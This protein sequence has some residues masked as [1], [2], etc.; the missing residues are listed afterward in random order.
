M[1]KMVN[2]PLGE[3]ANASAERNTAMPELRRLMFFAVLL[4]VGLYLGIG[5]IVDLIVPR[6]ST[7]TEAKLFGSATFGLAVSKTPDDR[8]ERA[9]RILA[10]LTKDKSVPALQYRLAIIVSDKPNAFAF[11]GGRIGVTT[12]LL[13]LLEEDVELAFVLGHELGHFRNRD[14]LRGMGRAI[15][16]GVAYAVVFGGDM[17][18]GSL[19]KI[20]QYILQRGYSR[21]QENSADHFGVDLVYR[22]YGKTDGIDELFKILH[23]AKDLPEWAYMFSTHPSPGDRI[24]KLQ[25]YADELAAGDG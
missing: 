17:G 20:F 18:N 15:G 2:R 4:A 7:E 13:D 12:G 23:Q 22:A 3:A 5:L 21:R 6:I 14:H 8:L 9:E 10:E 19:S 16:V 25:S 11:P 1:M 24:D